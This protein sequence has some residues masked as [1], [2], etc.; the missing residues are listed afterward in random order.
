MGSPETGL[1]S[2]SPTTID[3]AITAPASELSFGGYVEAAKE[4][5]GEG[6]MRRAAARLIDMVMHF[7]FTWIGGAILGI[8]LGV[9]ALASG[10]PLDEM[11]RRLSERTVYD[12]AFSMLGSLFMM[13]IL[14]AMHGSTVG[15]HILGMVVV[16][17]DGSPCTWKAAG[18]RQLGYYVDA[19]FFGIVGY[20]AMQGDERRQRYGDG[21]AG[22]IVCQ[23]G[24]IKP[25][26]LRS[27]GT[28]A[29]VLILAA[30]AD[31]ILVMIPALIKVL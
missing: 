7:G 13:M 14:E 27:G 19:L 10:H 29:G 18:I 2:G 1:S 17:E 25:E 26:N 12:F 20:T 11:L 3:S 31:M 9:A 28:F 5:K 16:M 24:E 30:M 23:R 8:L 4:I 22:T 15:K 21:W 6:F